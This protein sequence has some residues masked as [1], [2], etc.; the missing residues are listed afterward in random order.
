MKEQY[1][2]HTRDAV[3]YEDGQLVWLDG[4][5]LT[6]ARPMSKLEHRRFG[7]F[8]ILKKIGASAY[9]LQL[10]APWKAKR[11][12]DVFNESLLRPY[13]AP[14]YPSQVVPP[15]PPPEIIDDE[16]HYEVERILEAEEAKIGRNKFIRFHVKW[17][18]YP[19]SD[20]SW[21]WLEDVVESIDL[22]REYYAKNPKA[23]GHDTWEATYQ[24]LLKVDRGRSTRK[25]G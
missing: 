21:S 25:R 20:N 19:D 3:P 16:E 14:H 1:D 15:P 6:T 4:R 12:H 9:K 24:H 5:N 17:K 7:P 2:K 10:P 13:V 11:V 22:V 23:P 18:G 8:K